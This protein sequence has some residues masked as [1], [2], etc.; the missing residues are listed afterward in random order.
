MTALCSFDY[1][2]LII[3]ETKNNVVSRTS[4]FHLIQLNLEVHCTEQYLQ[5]SLGWSLHGIH[6]EEVQKLSLQ[7]QEAFRKRSSRDSFG[8]HHVVQKI[9]PMTLGTVQCKLTVHVNVEFLFNFFSLLVYQEIARPRQVILKVLKI[10]RAF[11]RVQF[12]NFQNHE[13]LL[14][15]NCA[16]SCDFLFIV[17]STKLRTVRE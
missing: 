7:N 13:Y 11:R 16:R 3:L 1:S 2:T 8:D 10:A 15:T 9:D 14:I 5:C 17:H 6:C 12:E 4:P